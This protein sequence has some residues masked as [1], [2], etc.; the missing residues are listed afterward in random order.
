MASA[1]NRVP[2]K[3]IRPIILAA[4]AIGVGQ[5]CAPVSAQN[6]FRATNPS[7]S[8]TLTAGTMPCAAGQLIANSSSGPSV[9]NPFFVLPPRRC[10]HRAAAA[11]DQRRDTDRMG[12][13]E[14]P[15]R[16]LVGLADLD[17]RRP[18]R[19]GAR[20]RNRCAPRELHLHHVARIWRRRLCRVRAQRRAAGPAACGGADLLEPASH[21]RLRRDRRR[22]DIH[23]DGGARELSTDCVVREAPFTRC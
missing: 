16:P 14:H 5:V 15:G 17:E 3:S 23:A 6:P 19:L 4:A 21:H 7:S 11:L 9:T 13:P 20:D 1:R 18:W 8:L 10:R 22:A 12:R 2:L